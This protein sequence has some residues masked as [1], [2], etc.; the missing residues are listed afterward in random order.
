MGKIIDINKYGKKK[1]GLRQYTFKGNLKLG[2]TSVGFITILMVCMLSILYLIQTNRTVTYGFE[3]EKYDQEIESLREEKEKLELEAAKLRS[4]SQIKEN[5]EK[6]N[7]Q[8]ID[9]TKIS[10]YEV[11]KY[12]ALNN[13]RSSQEK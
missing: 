1:K 10:Y 7:M 11:K 5:L 9:P 8:D 4:T 3:I 2:V 13:K 12:L 6:L